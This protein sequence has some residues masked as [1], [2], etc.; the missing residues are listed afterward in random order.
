LANLGVPGVGE[1]VALSSE[2]DGIIGSGLENKS[3][4]MMEFAVVLNGEEYA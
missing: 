3:L 2:N 4:S 1:N